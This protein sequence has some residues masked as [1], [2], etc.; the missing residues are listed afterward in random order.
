[1]YRTL[2]NICT[3]TS[4]IVFKKIISVNA[5]NFFKEIIHITFKKK[6]QILCRYLVPVPQQI[7]F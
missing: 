5:L 7:Y 6:I 4:A 1:M 3:G 2:K